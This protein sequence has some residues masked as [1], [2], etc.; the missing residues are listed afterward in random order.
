M[1]I[2]ELDT[3]DNV[4]D[5]F[6]RALTLTHISYGVSVDG[7]EVKAHSVRGVVNAAGQFIPYEPSRKRR[8]I[9]GEDLAELLASNPKGN[10][11]RISDARL[12]LD[13]IEQRKAKE[14]QDSIENSRRTIDASIRKQQESGDGK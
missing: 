2:T 3:P 12:I 9:I 11:F 5:E 14:H 6:D 1:P 10:D 4:T 8:H 7:E 13:K